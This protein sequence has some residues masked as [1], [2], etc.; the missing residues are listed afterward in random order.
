MFP[1]EEHS[2]PKFETTDKV[3]V[4]LLNSHRIAYKREDITLE[5]GCVYTNYH[6][7]RSN[8]EEGR[9]LTSTQVDNFIKDYNNLFDKFL[10]RY[11]STGIPILTHKLEGRFYD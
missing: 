2:K 9:A 8:K 11:Q 5:C 3:I 7:L 6:M 1:C 4:K 10:E